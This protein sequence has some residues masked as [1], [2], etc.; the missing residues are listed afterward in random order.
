MLTEQQLRHFRTFGCLVVPNL[1][2]P[3]QL[4]RLTGEFEKHSDW[5]PRVGGDDEVTSRIDFL[6]QSGRSALLEERRM[7]EVMESLLGPQALYMQNLAA[8]YP[9]DQSWRTIMGWHLG[10]SAGCSE[11]IG[12]FGAHNFPGARAIINLDKIDRGS[13]RVI[14]GSHR[15]PYHDKLWTLSADIARIRQDQPLVRD[16]VDALCERDEISGERRTRLFEDPAANCFEVDPPQVPHTALKIEPGDLLIL[17]HMLWHACYGNGA[18]RTIEIDWKG[19]PTAPS[20]TDWI[21]RQLP[22]LRA[23]QRKAEAG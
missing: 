14:V 7:T 19:P 15:P 6:E 5:L 2:Q 11:T 8:V 21:E 17:D 1:L 20:H 10:I 12:E 18:R 22:A 13:F 16:A 4:D 3:E 23:R 9:G